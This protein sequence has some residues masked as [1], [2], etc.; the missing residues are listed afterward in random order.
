MQELERKK[1]SLEQLK[2]DVQ[3]IQELSG[4]LD[5]ALIRLNEQL[6][7][8]RQYEKK[9]WDNIENIDRLRNDKEALRLA[10]EIIDGDTSFV[11]NIQ[12]IQT[13]VQGPFT[14]YFSQTL[15]TI[16]QQITKVNASIKELSDRGI[17]LEKEVERAKREDEARKKAEELARIKKE[18]ELKKKQEAERTIFTRMWQSV[19][20]TLS[21]WFAALTSYYTPSKP[22]APKPV[23]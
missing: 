19:T 11:A 13:Y 1:E 8:A 18:E 21:S 17:V 16:S 22:V 12:K 9:A 10:G 14:R 23:P 7:K 6:V 5:E 15:D 20:N 2:V 4:S 3:S